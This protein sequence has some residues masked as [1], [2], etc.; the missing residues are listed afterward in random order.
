MAVTTINKQDI[1]AQTEVL[2]L[3]SERDPAGL[4]VASAVLNALKARYALDAQGG[5]AEIKSDVDENEGKR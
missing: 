5:D 2:S 1:R 4:M 3:L